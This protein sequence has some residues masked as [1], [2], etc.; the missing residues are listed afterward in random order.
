MTGCLGHPML[1]EETPALLV[2][3]HAM[4]P[5]LT[6]PSTCY[7]WQVWRCVRKHDWFSRLEA[8]QTFGHQSETA[9]SLLEWVARRIYDNCCL[10]LDDQRRFPVGVKTAKRVCEFILRKC[11]EQFRQNVWIPLRLQFTCR[12]KRIREDRA[13]LVYWSLA[14]LHFEPSSYLV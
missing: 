8:A 3:A 1:L 6:P 5:S 13:S 4:K 2:I 7:I 10:P 12:F 9:V 11:L 14:V